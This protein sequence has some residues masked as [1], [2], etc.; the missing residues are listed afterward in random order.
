[1]KVFKSV[2]DVEGA[3]LSPPV[4]DVVHRVVK[5]FIDALAEYGQVYDPEDDGYT[6]LIE[7][8]DDAEV[9]AEIGYP[10]GDALFEG[11]THEDGAFVGCVLHNNQFGFSLIFIDSP[12]L[13]PVLR[14]RLVEECGGVPG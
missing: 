13:D 1:M 3:G 14:A 2:E 10:I 9:A 12:L 8:G 6:L 11:V 5:G 7:G 4:H